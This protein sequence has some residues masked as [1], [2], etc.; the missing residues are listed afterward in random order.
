MMNSD[1]LPNTSN[2]PNCNP[3]PI[4]LVQVATFTRETLVSPPGQPSEMYNGTYMYAIC[5]DR[6]KDCDC[7]GIP[8]AARAKVEQLPWFVDPAVFGVSV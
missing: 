3:N 4:S 7:N 5:C 6:T 1:T 2:N 8:L